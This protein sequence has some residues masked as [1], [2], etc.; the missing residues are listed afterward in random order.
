MRDFVAIGELGANEESEKNS[1]GIWGHC[2][3]PTPNGIQ[4]KAPE[5][6]FDLTLIS[7]NLKTYPTMLKA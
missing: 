5:K 6:F 2:K 7:F 1:W 4:G 3:P